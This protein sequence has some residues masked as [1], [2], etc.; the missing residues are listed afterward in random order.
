ME[1]ESVISQAEYEIYTAL[2]QETRLFLFHRPDTIFNDYTGDNPFYR[3][4]TNEPRFA[5][6]FKYECLSRKGMIEDYETKNSR[7]WRLEKKFQVENGYRFLSEIEPQEHQKPR[8]IFTL[9]RVGFDHS[10]HY[11]L[12]HI[13]YSACGY[14]FLFNYNLNGWQRQLYFMSY[15]I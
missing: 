3:Y 13:A 6:A 11:G 2:C 10:G 14:Y 9:S 1:T 5:G 4:H 7:E 15:V 12:V 8:G